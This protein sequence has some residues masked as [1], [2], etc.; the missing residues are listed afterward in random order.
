LAKLPRGAYVRTR[1]IVRGTAL[2]HIEMTLEA[3]LASGFPDA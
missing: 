2:D 1:S 3:D